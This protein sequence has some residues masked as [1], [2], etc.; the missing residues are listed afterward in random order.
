MKHRII[1]F[2]FIL[3]VACKDKPQPPDNLIGKEE[4]KE[5]L[6]D[7]AMSDVVVEL[8]KLENNKDIYSEKYA[9]FKSILNKYDVEENQFKN[10]YKYYLNNLDSANVMYDQMIEEMSIREAELNNKP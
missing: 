1:F 4:M 3:M 7:M 2:S 6:I 9:L 5:I 8:K 10:S